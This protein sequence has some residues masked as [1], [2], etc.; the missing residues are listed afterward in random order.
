MV[1]DV[2]GDYS[3]SEISD[4]L[5]VP[6]Q[7]INSAMKSMIQNDLA[8]LEVAPEQSKKKIIRLTERGSVY[9]AEQILPLQEAEKN[10]FLLLDVAERDELVRL[11]GKYAS[12]LQKELAIL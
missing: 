11:S 8:T 10:A 3:Q 4:A 5:S 12:N 6:K 7:T 1:S 2:Y 9:T